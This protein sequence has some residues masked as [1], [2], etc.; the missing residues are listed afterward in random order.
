M[1][2]IVFHPV[3]QRVPTLYVGVAGYF[4][5]APKFLLIFNMFI[6]EWGLSQQA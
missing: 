1:V 2:P 3:V 5:I 4:A 6:V